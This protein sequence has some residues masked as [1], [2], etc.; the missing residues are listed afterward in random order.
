MNYIKAAVELADGFGYDDCKIHDWDYVRLP[1]D[2]TAMHDLGGP[3]FRTTYHPA[4]DALAAQL[5]RQVDAL[6]GYSVG[7][8]SQFDQANRA[9]VYGRKFKAWR[10]YLISDESGPDRTMNTIKAIVDSGVLVAT[11]H[12]TGN[13]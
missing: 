3:L 5:V 13:E 7:V 11:E 8:G 10:G 12:E 4:L 9:A 2:S 6:D 1:D